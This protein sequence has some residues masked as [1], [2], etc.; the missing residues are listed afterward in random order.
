[1]VWTQI[2]KGVAKAIDWVVDIYTKFKDKIVADGKIVIPE[3][4]SVEKISIEKIRLTIEQKVHI[5]QQE[6]Q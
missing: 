1:M 4:D 5:L 2:K 3:L 6:I